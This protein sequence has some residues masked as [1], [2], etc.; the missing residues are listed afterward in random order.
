M[1][2]LILVAGGR[3]CTLAWKLAQSENCGNLFIAPG[4]AGTLDYGMIFKWLL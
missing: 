2:I 4:N 1:N 3:E